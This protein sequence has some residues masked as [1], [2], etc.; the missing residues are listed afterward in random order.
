[1]MATLEVARAGAGSGKTTDLCRT[2]ANA[3]QQGLDPARILATTFTKKA[4]A[5]L[6]GRIQASLLDSS[7]GTATSHRQADRL[8]L[9]AIGTVHSVAHHLLSRYAIELG[10]SPRLEVIAE[11]ASERALRDLLGTIPASSWQL[12]AT[13][14]E[15][16]AIN[17]LHRRIIT[18]LASK[19][20]NRISDTDFSAHVA[21]SAER[22]CELL[23]LSGPVVPETPI[24]QLYDLC[25]QAL[26]NIDALNDTQKNTNAARRKLQRIKAG[27]MP[28]WTSYLEAIGITAGRRSGA[29]A[30]LN[31]LR[32]HAGRV[33]QNPALHADIREF[34]ARLA[35][36]IIQLDAEYCRYKTERG[37]VDFTDLEILFLGLLE[38]NELSLHLAADF[39]LVLVD[40]FQDTNPLQLAIF[41]RLRHLSPR[42]RWVGD[43]KQAIF[44]FRDTD[45]ELVNS[46][47]DAVPDESRTELPDNHRSQRGL[48]QFVG[49]MFAPIFGDD[50]RQNPQKP[51]IERGVE[52]WVFDA[53]NQAE[54]ALALACGVAALHA[55]GIRFGDMVVLER[56][57]RHLIPLG[58]ALNSL[59][60]PYLLESPGLL[61]TRE[62][63]LVMAGL[64]LVADRN[65]SLAA[66]TVL[67]L[68]GGPD[69]VTPDWIIDRLR[70]LNNPETPPDDTTHRVPWSGHATFLRLENIDRALSSPALVLN[71]VI[72]A[73]DLPTCVHDWG[74]P[75]RRCSNLDSLL[76]H[77]REYEE[78]A[79]NTGRA[80]TLTGLI[81]FFEELAADN[82]DF[83]YPPEGHDAV[84][85]MTYHSAKGLEWPVV[86]LSGLNSDR[87]PNMWSPV[88]TGGGGA[89][90]DPLEGRTLR[91]W[92]WPFGMTEGEFPKLRSGSN[93][94]T[95]AWVSPEGQNRATSEADENL[96]LLYVGCTRAK[97]KLVFAHRDGR[98]AWLSQ[99][100]EIDSLLDCTR[101]EGEYALDR[102]DTTFVVRQLTPAT[103]DE[104]RVRSPE[105]EVWIS[106]TMAPVPPPPMLRYHSPSQQPPESSDALFRMEELP[107]PAHFPSGANEEHYAAFG[108]AVHSYLASLPSTRTFT[109]QQKE[110]IAERCFAAFSV[111]GLLSPSVLVSTGARFCDWVDNNYP[112]ARWLVEVPMSALRTAGGQW[113]GVGDL[114]LQLPSDEVVVIDHKSA[115]IRRAHC[116]AKAMTFAGQLQAY[117]EILTAAGETVR[118]NVIHFPMAGVLAELQLE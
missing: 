40:E 103:A 14:A 10:L 23:L 42:S 78:T 115:P 9:A 94:E 93:L 51:R 88:V 77:A 101:G 106:P 28:L 96:R 81:L 15:R 76:R 32:T 70:T 65:D 38:D 87:S 59:G 90:N 61:Q 43:P 31:T 55:E 56:T 18:L 34:S 72:E 58:D 112:G 71:Q 109:S 11:A 114:L 89:G 63:A 116:L 7:G 86:I 108:D 37:L 75:G 13:C 68:L 67:H 6:K 82:R 64:R 69:K 50:A 41:Q 105:D 33:R 48:V 26:T 62:G 54:D 117:S 84:T 35:A 36:E 8:D 111:T 17:D 4:A 27:Q 25:E 92:T 22:V 97:Q 85:I 91:A 102:I 74:D 5:E 3:V 118:S 19:R 16:L 30:F 46:I 2:V 45:P 29:D 57:N 12:L 52:R 66:A 1:M 21:A 107:G 113:T 83:W 100:P 80:A 99:I 73:L 79:L 39:D 44:G 110:M 98:Y 53:R 104:S 24:N 49:T 95:D 47:W 60:I 20:G